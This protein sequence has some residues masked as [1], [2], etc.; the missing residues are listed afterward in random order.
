VPYLNK[1][2]SHF[3]KNPFHQ[4]FLTEIVTINLRESFFNILMNIKRAEFS[5]L[6]LTCRETARVNLHAI[7]LTPDSGFKVFSASSLSTAK[8][9]STDSDTKELSTEYD[10]FHLQKINQFTRQMSSFVSMLLAETG[11]V[12]SLNT[13][14]LNCQNISWLTLSTL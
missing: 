5:S 2:L 14:A 9:I 11:K 8:P 1:S 12:S 13:C 10:H 4:G 7:F 6:S 3:N